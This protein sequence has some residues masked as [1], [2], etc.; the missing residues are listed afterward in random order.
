MDHRPCD[1]KGEAAGR[2]CETRHR[3]RLSFVAAPLDVDRLTRALQL[4]EDGELN[5]AMKLLAPIVRGK[6]FTRPSQVH[7][8]PLEVSEV[9]GWLK[10]AIE[11]PGSDDARFYVDR[12]YYKLRTLRAAD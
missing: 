7:A 4:I 1:G 12:A 6:R 5:D 3:V 11:D 10:N 9:E 2:A 8:E